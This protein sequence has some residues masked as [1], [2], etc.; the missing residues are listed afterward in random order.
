MILCC[1]APPCLIIYQY[2]MR[3]GGGHLPTIPWGYWLGEEKH[4]QSLLYYDSFCFPDTFCVLGGFGDIF[5][6][7]NKSLWFPHEIILNAK[8]NFRKQNGLWS[9]DLQLSVCLC[10]RHTCASPPVMAGFGHQFPNN[11]FADKFFEI[12]L[13]KNKL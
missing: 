4:I 3:E 9:I 6:T 11:N 13:E 12:L 5:A 2:L 1:A 7:R 10:V 8:F